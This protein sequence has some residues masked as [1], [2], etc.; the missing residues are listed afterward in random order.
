M[1]KSVKICSSILAAMLALSMSAR[2]RSARL[3]IADCPKRTLHV[4]RVNRIKRTVIIMDHARQILATERQVLAR[5]EVATHLL[6]RPIIATAIVIQ[7]P[8]RQETAKL[9]L[10]TAIAIQAVARQETAIPKS[11]TATAIPAIVRQ[12]IAIQPRF[13]LHTPRQ[14][15]AITGLISGIAY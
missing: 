7:V 15:K 9:K 13:L 3:P 8:A 5:P 10:A 14:R 2:P 11:A 4:R 1:K 6:I 12:A